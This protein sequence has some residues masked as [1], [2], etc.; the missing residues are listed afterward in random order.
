MCYLLVTELSFK[1]NFLFFSFGIHLRHRC[2]MYPV[3]IRFIVTINLKFKLTHRI[4]KSLRSS[5]VPF[6]ELQEN[7]TNFRV[8][9]GPLH[10][11]DFRL[12]NTL[13]IYLPTIDPLSFSRV[14]G[15]WSH[16]LQTSEIGKGPGWEPLYDHLNLGEVSPF[17]FTFGVESSLSTLLDSTLP[18]SPSVSVLG[19]CWD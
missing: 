15:D 12:V 6:R 4:K 19:S 8:T 3:W 14:L 9:S 13:Y 11:L 7:S 17:T 1:I 2:F 16:P 10:Q 5:G 18:E